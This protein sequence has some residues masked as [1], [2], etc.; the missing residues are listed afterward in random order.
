MMAEA[1]PFHI[2]GLK[3]EGLPVPEP[4]HKVGTIAA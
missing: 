3:L 1:I 4:H 2:E